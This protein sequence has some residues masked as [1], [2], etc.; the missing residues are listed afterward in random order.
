MSFTSMWNKFNAVMQEAIRQFV[1][2]TITDDK[3]VL[4]TI[5]KKH[6]L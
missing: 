3:K 2:K 4:K 6:H 1:Q 5:K